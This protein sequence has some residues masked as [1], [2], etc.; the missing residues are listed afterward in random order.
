MSSMDAM[1]ID[2]M[3]VTSQLVILIVSVVVGIRIINNKTINNMWAFLMPL[4]IT[5]V[6]IAVATELQDKYLEGVKSLT[7]VGGL[8][9]ILGLLT[10]GI[11]TIILGAYMTI[12]NNARRRQPSVQRTIR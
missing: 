7:I 4:I 5:V 12:R 11:N 6:V 2:Y 8:Y 3:I 9:F 10:F 1:Y